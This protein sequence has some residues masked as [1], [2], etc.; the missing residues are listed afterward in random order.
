VEREAVG[1]LYESH[2]RSLL[3]YACSFAPDVA[4]AERELRAALAARRGKG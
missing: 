4:A 3:A 1:K 2:G